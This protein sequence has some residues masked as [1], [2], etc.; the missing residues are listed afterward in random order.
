MVVGIVEIIG[1]HHIV[2]TSN[3]LFINPNLTTKGIIVFLYRKTNP[4]VV[5]IMEDVKLDI[6]LIKEIVSNGWIIQNIIDGMENMMLVGFV[7]IN[8]SI[9]FK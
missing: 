5:Q 1:L 8:Q 9:I 7:Q 4:I 3:F 6:V 2:K